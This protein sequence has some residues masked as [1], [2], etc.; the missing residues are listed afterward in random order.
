MIDLGRDSGVALEEALLILCRL[1]EGSTAGLDAARAVLLTH[2]V[3]SRR[4]LLR[5]ELFRWL[6]AQLYGVVDEVARPDADQTHGA[7]LCLADFIQHAVRRLVDCV[8]A[9]QGPRQRDAAV[10]C[11]EV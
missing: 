5:L 3:E 1:V 9:V 11:R 6:Q 10:L 8:V 4:Q 2:A 7:P